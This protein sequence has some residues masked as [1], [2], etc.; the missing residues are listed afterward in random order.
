MKSLLTILLVC[1]GISL[2][3]QVAPVRQQM[4]FTNVVTFDSTCIAPYVASPPLVYVVA[5]ADTVDAACDIQYHILAPASDID[6]CIVTLLDSFSV[7]GS[8]L[9]FLPDADSISVLIIN[10][11]SSK[12]FINKP[13]TIGTGFN[14]LYSDSLD[15]WIKTP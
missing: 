5:N 7:D 9:T 15:S 10:S 2:F 6:S 13:S 11:E 4:R 3:A 8:R 14:L 12:S 1:F